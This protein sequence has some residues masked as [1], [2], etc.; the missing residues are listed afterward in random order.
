MYFPPRTD[1]PDYVSGVGLGGSIRSHG[2]NGRVVIN[3]GTPTPPDIVLDCSEGTQAFPYTGVNQSFTLPSSCPAPVAVMAKLWGAGGAS[4]GAGYPMGAPSAT[5]VTMSS[6]GG[7]GFAT[8][9]FIVNPGET[10][11]VITGRGGVYFNAVL[12]FGGGGPGGNAGGGGRSAIRTGPPPGNVEII[13]AG[14]GGGAG[15]GPGHAA[16][17][18][19]TGTVYRPGTQF[20]GGSAIGSFG[21]GGGGGG[22]QGGPSSINTGPGGGGGSNCVLDGLIYASTMPGSGSNPAN[23]GD[24]DYVGGIGVGVT[25]ENNGGNGLIIIQWNSVP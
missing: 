15:E 1:D 20:L 14:G 22:C 6:G 21:G 3:W 18:P 24:P 19:F 13:T 11:T 8:G 12:A 25:G 4:N 23:T 16:G 5:P 9:I 10:Y 7:G 2:G 17:T